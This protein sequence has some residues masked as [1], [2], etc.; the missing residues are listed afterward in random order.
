MKMKLL[1]LMLPALISPVYFTTF[2]QTTL[3]QTSWYAG[4]GLAG[5]RLDWDDNR[6]LT[7]DN[8]DF[9][10]SEGYLTISHD[11]T[12]IDS[13]MMSCSYMVAID[14]DMDGDDD[15]F[16]STE[17]EG[18]LKWYENIS[19]GISWQEH[20]VSTAI[21][22][23]YRFA[24]ADFQ[25]DGICEL[26]AVWRSEGTLLFFQ[27]ESGSWTSSVIADGLYEPIGVCI[28]DMNNDLLPDIVVTEM[29]P[30]QWGGISWFENTNSGPT[31]WV[32]HTIATNMVGPTTVYAADYDSDGDLDLSVVDLFGDTV[33]LC[34]NQNQSESWTVHTVAELVNPEA[35]PFADIDG[36][37]NLDI[38]IAELGLNP[39]EYAGGLRWA[40]EAAEGDW[41]LEDLDMDFVRPHW[42]GSADI[43]QDGDIDVY[44][45]Q[46]AY[47]TSVHSLCSWWENL[48]SGITWDR[49]DVWVWYFTGGEQ[50]SGRFI[51]DADFNCDG[52]V[53]F[54]VAPYTFGDVTAKI[55]RV[56][57][58][59]YCSN[60]SITSTV[61]YKLLPTDWQ[62]F[63]WNAD[64]PSGTSACFQVRSGDTFEDL[65]EWS[66]TLYSSCSLDGIIEDGNQYFQYRAIMQSALPFTAPELE[67]VTLVLQPT[68]ISSD[69]IPEN[70]FNIQG[71]PNPAISPLTVSFSISQSSDIEI[72]CFDISGRLASNMMLNDLL[73]GSHSTALPYLPAGIYLVRFKAAGQTAFQRVVLL[74]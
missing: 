74:N 21:D 51:D 46:V 12:L 27:Y 38:I 52:K 5:P 72:C 60:A 37:G 36:S 48:D 44:A 57:P 20:F 53:D 19:M 8:A 10:I 39:P 49:H 67:D 16:T 59:L 34:E 58:N 66:D 55:Y 23:V 2:A 6:F 40:H 63:S 69:D 18:G 32:K 33:Y 3:E 47:D 45:T 65:G 4:P 13:T 56:D 1:A 35:A 50:L 22:S 17:S 71:I 14:F 31:G 70:T 61:I 64:C 62:S 73:P 9:G 15:L 30:D 42:C 25:Q 26:V 68:G 43:D 28:G 29:V 11:N 41:I 54:A 7:G 24:L